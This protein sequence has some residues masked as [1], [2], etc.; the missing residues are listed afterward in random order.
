LGYTLADSGGLSPR[1]LG[2][3]LAD[4]GCALM[5]WAVPLQFD[6]SLEYFAYRT[7]YSKGWTIK[8]A[9]GSKTALPGAKKSAPQSTIFCT[10]ISMSKASRAN[11]CPPNSLPTL[12]LPPTC[13][14]HQRQCR[15]PL[16]A[17]CCQTTTNA[18]VPPPCQ[19][20]PPSSMSP[21]QCCHFTDRHLQEGDRVRHAGSA[22]HALGGGEI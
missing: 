11:C 4:L 19:S 13:H 15:R 3:A 2:C 16:P 9:P 21:H 5:A 20:P 7:D 1:G 10:M 6:S 18:T 14:Q 17:N 8:S 22:M 12:P